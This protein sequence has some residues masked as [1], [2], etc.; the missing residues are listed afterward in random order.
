MGSEPIRKL[1]VYRLAIPL[2]GRVSHAAS[3]RVAAESV[4]VVVELNSGTIGYGETLPRKY[5]TGES[6]DTVVE[7]IER[8][9]APGLVEAHPSSFAHALELVDE[10]PWR[11]ARG[12]LVPAARAAVELALLDAYS[13]RFKRPIDDAVGWLGLNAFGSPGSI[14]SIRHAGVLATTDVGKFKRLLRLYWWYGLRDFKVKVGDPDDDLRLQI[15]HTY[16]KRPLNS[17]RATLRVDVNGAWSLDT[18]SRTLDDWKDIPLSAVEQPLAKGAESDLAELKSC[19]H[20]PLM[21]DESLVMADDADRLIA[22]GVA[23]AFNIRISK[24]GGL[25]PSLKLAGTA[26]KHG[27][28]VQLGCMVGETSILSAVARKFLELVP[29]VRFAEGNFGSFLVSRDVVRRPLRFGFRGAIRPL[30]GFGWGVDV[31]ATLLENAAEE[32]VSYVF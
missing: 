26:L 13:R 12:A 19:V 2:R 24:C 22:L 18:A 3:T 20:P 14:R 30:E 6:V 28:M 10:L 31:E 5:V 25:L 21:Y 27:V 1:S 29:G 4:V 9:Y 7:A 8:T 23:D 32:T 15:A 16:L 11:D 17:G